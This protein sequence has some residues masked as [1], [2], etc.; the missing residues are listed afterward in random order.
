MLAVLFVG[1]FEMV[2]HWTNTYLMVVHNGNNTTSSCIIPCGILSHSGRQ[3]LASLHGHLRAPPRPRA[4]YRR[5]GG[6][7]Q[8]NPR[9]E[10]RRIMA[11]KIIWLYGLQNSSRLSIRRV[12]PPFRLLAVVPAGKSRLLT[13]QVCSIRQRGVKL[14]VLFWH[15]LWWITKNTLGNT[16]GWIFQTRQKKT[17]FVYFFVPIFV[18]I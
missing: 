13:P 8:A 1:Q 17:R 18:F 6:G 5:K 12:A 7:P 15:T 16:A 2:L 11:Y 10:T 9:P 14:F 4:G 3:R